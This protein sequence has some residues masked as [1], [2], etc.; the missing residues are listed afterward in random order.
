VPQQKKVE[1]WLNHNDGRLYVVVNPDQTNRELAGP[2][3]PNEVYKRW[4]TPFD[5]SQYRQINSNP[6]NAASDEVVHSPPEAFGLPA[7]NP[8]W[9]QIMDDERWYIYDYV[10]DVP[11]Q[12]PFAQFKDYYEN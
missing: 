8:R 10:V 9:P 6:V 5:P 7:I 11:Q 1:V 12:Q 2:G 4:C 3:G